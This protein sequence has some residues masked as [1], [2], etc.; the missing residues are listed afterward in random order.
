MLWNMGSFFAVQGSS[1]AYFT[2]AVAFVTSIGSSFSPLFQNELPS[3]LLPFSAWESLF[4][5]TVCNTQTK[6]SVCSAVATNIKPSPIHH[7]LL[8]H[9]VW[10][11]YL[12]QATVTNTASFSP[13]FWFP[14]PQPACLPL[15]TTLL[16][17]QGWHVPPCSL[18]VLRELHLQPDHSSHSCLLATKK[19]NPQS[20]SSALVIFDNLARC[21]DVE[22]GTV[23]PNHRQWRSARLW[24]GRFGTAQK[25]GCKLLSIDGLFQSW[26]YSNLDLSVNV[27]DYSDL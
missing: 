18:P 16:P 13:I 5:D 11:T 10:Q 8:A 27:Y 24:R 4:W 1:N 2:L 6:H 21:P 7:G 17:S 3:D 26:H 25:S 9:Y 15:H 14:S 23:L 19:T 22:R 12:V 20:S